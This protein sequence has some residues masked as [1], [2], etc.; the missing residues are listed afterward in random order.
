M[1]FHLGLAWD[2][3]AKHDCWSHFFTASGNTSRYIGQWFRWSLWTRCH[4]SLA[5]ILRN[6]QAFANIFGA[7]NPPLVEICQRRLVRPPV[8]GSNGIEVERDLFRASFL[9]LPTSVS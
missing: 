9:T 4:R 6:V 1:I 8:L 2:P 5:S 7:D 3:G